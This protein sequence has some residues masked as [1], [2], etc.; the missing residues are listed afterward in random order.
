MKK[1]LLAEDEAAARLS[2]AFALKRGGFEVEAVK[3]GKEAFSKLNGGT[4]GFSLVLTDIQMPEMTGLELIEKMNDLEY[5]IPIIVM[6]AY[7]DKDIV[8]D[9]MRL[10]CS[11]YID[12]PFEPK[13]IITLITR[14][15]DKEEKSKLKIKESNG[16]SAKEKA[17]LETQYESYKL[18]FEKLREQIDSAVGAYQN[19]VHIDK[20]DLN[21]SVAYN[22][23][24]LSDLGGDF[25]GI[26]NTPY[27]CDVFLA[28]VAGHDMGASYH[29][30]LIK[31]LFEENI[32]KRR[33]GG[34]FFKRL[35]TLLRDDGKNERMVT[36]IYLSIN[37]KEMIGEV[38]S[39]AHPYPL[40]FDRNCTKP[41]SITVEG[42]ILGI[43]DEIEFESNVFK[44]NPGQRIFMFTDGVTEAQ[45]I[46]GETGKKEKIGDEFFEKRIMK[47]SDLELEQLV[48]SI[49]KDILKF[50]NYKYKDDMTIV[51]I[52]IPKIE[53]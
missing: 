7:G 29:T 4:N 1:I 14:V 11:E 47:Y 41:A 46:D 9:L 53:K 25:L 8:V 3:N 31:T 34:E 5:N 30:I 23:Q 33:S 17:E 13:E 24:A 38:F 43:Y 37:L 52:E 42:D 35:N 44:I 48:D 39:A 32:K 6:T 28:D 26:K 36:G 15:L 51:S 40:L 20:E 49:W 16:A 27:G 21:L 10:G 12:K 50:C 45:K 22:M 2:L 18:E 19:L